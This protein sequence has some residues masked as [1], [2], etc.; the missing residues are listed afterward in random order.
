MYEEIIQKVKEITNDYRN[1]FSIEDAKKL[2]LHKGPN[3][4]CGNRSQLHKN[5]NVTN[6]YGS[7][8][9][10]RT[11]SDTDS[12]RN[13]TD[14]AD[15]IKDFKENC[16]IIKGTI[17][18][19]I[20]SVKETGKTSRPIR[21]DIKKHYSKYPCVVC[22]SKS[23]LVCDHKNDLYNDPRVLNTKT[24]K[25]EDFQSLCNS[26][27]LRKRAVSIQSIKDGKRFGAT[28]LEQFKPLGIDYTKG[29]ET[30]NL[31]DPQALI[32][33]YWYDPPAFMKEAM[34]MYECKIKLTIYD[35]IKAGLKQLFK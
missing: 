18:F 27:N 26:C 14:Y 34:E 11:Y 17:G 31:D 30:L 8:T 20:H 10:P 12:D 16:K 28:N 33:T 6:I 32:G 19:I 24:Q 25:P 35:E 23:S 21:P 29:N 3:N 5:F 13:I 1:V 4:G 9:P 2:G 22:G 7:K 15:R